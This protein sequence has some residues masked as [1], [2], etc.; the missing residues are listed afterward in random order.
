VTDP[1]VPI[2][3]KATDLRTLSHVAYGLYAI[4]LV[5][6]GF[7]GVAILAAVVL[8]YLKRADT[9]G[10]VYAP[11]FDWLLRTFWWSLLWFALSALLTLIAIGWLGIIAATVWTLY[12]LIKGWLALLEGRAPTAEA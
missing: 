8:L 1:Q 4:G 7:L 6:A 10:T 12:R 3:N 11:H 2:Y 5:T 9:A